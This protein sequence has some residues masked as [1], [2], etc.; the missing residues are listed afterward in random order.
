MNRREKGDKGEEIAIRFLK[1]RGYRILDRNFFT[2]QGEIDIIARDRKGLAF[3][4]VKMRNSKSC[5]YPAEAVTGTKA[6][7]IQKTALYYLMKKK[8]KDM[9]YRFEVL[10]IL[11][12]GAGDYT[13]EI[14]P[15][16][17]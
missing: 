13:I 4:E 14:I 6:R 2:H 3:V 10:S 15:L 8:M 17:F 12:S 7:H 16:E 11:K 5:G 1:R 9:P